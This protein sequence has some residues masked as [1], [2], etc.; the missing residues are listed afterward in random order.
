MHSRTFFAATSRLRSDM[1]PALAIPQLASQRSEHRALQ[2][3]YK[4]KEGIDGAYSTARAMIQN[5]W[6]TT[7]H[8]TPNLA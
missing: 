5:D 3:G 6:R 1:V 4:R 7:L 2:A 8:I